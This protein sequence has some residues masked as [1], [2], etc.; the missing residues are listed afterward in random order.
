MPYNTKIGNAFTLA[1]IG[2]SLALILTPSVL[3]WVHSV[4]NE[5]TAHL[6]PINSVAATLILL[7]ALPRLWIGL[8]LLAPWILLAPLEI[9]YV[10]SFGSSSDV[11]VLG[12]LSETNWQE[13]SAFLGD[14]L[15]WILAILACS[16][17]LAITTPLLAWHKNLKWNGRARH[18]ILA[19]C[20]LVIMTP[21]LAILVS[22]IDYQKNNKT[23]Y[24]TPSAGENLAINGS[25]L[26]AA[27]LIKSY[28]AGVLL[29]LNEHQHHRKT[30]RVLS[31]QLTDFHFEASR[32]FSA[33][34]LYPKR[35]VYVL[36][37]GESSR[38]DHWQLNGYE[39][40]TTPKLATLTGITSFTNMVSPWSWTRMSVPVIITRKLG[41]IATPFFPEKSVISAFREADF[42]TYWFSTQGTLG[43][44]ESSIALHAHEAHETKFINPSNY[45]QRAALDGELLRLLNEALAKNEPRQL[46]VLHTLGSHYNYSHRYP[47]I[48]DHF[49]P[50]LN[51][52]NHPD[53]HD[54]SQR[55]AMRNSY[56]NS[57]LY[58]D[59]VLSE[60]I[61]SLSEL[62]DT[63]T[64]LFYVSDHGENLFD[65]YC[66]LSGHGRMT[67]RDFRVASFFWESPLYAKH[68]PTKVDAIRAHIHSPL[69]TENVFHSLLDMADI[70]LPNENLSASVFHPNL[71]PQQR[72]LQ[73]GLDFDN[74]SRDPVCQLLQ[75]P[76]VTR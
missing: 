27:E 41:S 46:I 49:T 76:L 17:A 51:Q 60:T 33:A 54:R 3:I 44:H 8:I 57:I 21:W 30:L 67:E 9:W 16:T 73:N 7:L 72:R 35:E 25:P 12:I 32:P 26:I 52:V 19:C 39:R 69:T 59:F 15:H 28:P 63:A 71:K 50:S 13:I 68:F 11:H 34:N 36:V 74:A 23:T 61:G 22:E 75:P 70:R 55:E 1:V 43:I 29:R 56:D 65:G 64:G 38:P 42:K 10:T 5:A 37:I 47:A 18:W 62:T 66:N 20:L 53:L 4:A 48:F 58:T 45:R 2:T 24:N 14:R 40:E 6:V 31:R